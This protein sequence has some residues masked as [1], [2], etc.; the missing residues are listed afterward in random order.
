MT[1]QHQGAGDCPT[2]VGKMFLRARE[3]VW[4]GWLLDDLEGPEARQDGFDR[5]PGAEGQQGE[6]AAAAVRCPSSISRR[7]TA[8]GAWRNSAE[9][10]SGCAL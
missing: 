2:G 1:D 10:G 7:K 4:A 8:F 3:I 6:T 5:I 9:I